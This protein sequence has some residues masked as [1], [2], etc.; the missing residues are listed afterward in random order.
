LFF[1]RSA[2]LYLRD[3]GQ[4]GFVLPKSI[5]VADQHHAFRQGNHAA[6]LR[7]LKAWDL[8]GVRPLF[9]VPASVAFGEKSPKEAE[10][11]LTGLTVAG[12]LEM[13]NAS[14]EEA[15]EHLTEKGTQYWLSIKARG[16]TSAR[17]KKKPSPTEVLTGESSPK[18]QRL[19]RALS[20]LWKF[21]SL[22]VSATTRQGHTSRPIPA[23]SRPLKSNTRTCA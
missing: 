1:V 11:P 20:G 23:Q 3:G 6:H 7:L 4:I 22:R 9:N 8:E 12:E 16:A 5:F 2:D 15:A 10:W 18:A 19:S 17:K 13:R 14:P 21:Q